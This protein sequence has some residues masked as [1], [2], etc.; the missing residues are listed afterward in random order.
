MKWQVRFATV[1]IAAALIAGLQAWWLFKKVRIIDS[2]ELYAKH[3]VELRA[4]SNW[5][6]GYT[7]SIHGAS[8]VKT[9]NR[10]QGFAGRVSEHP[11]ITAYMRRELDRLPWLAAYEGLFYLV[12]IVVLIVAA[13]VAYWRLAGA[14]RSAS[15]RSVAIGMVVGIAVLLFLLP[16]IITGYG[17][18]A[19]TTWAGP[20]AMSSSGPY[21]HLS[22]W[23]GETISYRPAIEVLTIPMMKPVARLGGHWILLVA[24]ATAYAWV[25]ARLV[26]RVRGA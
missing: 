2:P 13:P 23:P 5:R 15:R 8:L 18:S 16:S 3:V 9:A 19:F 10:G 1:L 22:W 6:Y 21:A 17:S 24:L 26:L 20:Y 7:Q 14:E 25:V 12:W 4:D 11:E